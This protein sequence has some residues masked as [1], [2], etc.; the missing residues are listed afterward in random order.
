MQYTNRKGVT[1]VLQAG[2]TKTGKPRYYAARKLTGEPLESIPQGYEVWEKPADGI[3]Y[4]RKARPTTVTQAERELLTELARK[5]AKTKHFLVDVDG[6]SLVVY[7]GEDNFGPLARLIGS[8]DEL[9]SLMQ[10]SKMFRFRV[11]DETERVFAV[12]RWCFLGG[13]DDWFPL[14]GTGSLSECAETFLPHLG[15]ESFYEL[16]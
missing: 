16:M 10:F 11:I 3:V 15:S 1:Y 12:D 6:N 8:V 9:V 7:Q 5:Y 13:I 2:V 14:A 4:I